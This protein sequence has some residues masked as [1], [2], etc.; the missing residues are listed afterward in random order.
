MLELESEAG[1]GLVVILGLP[2]VPD[3]CRDVSILEIPLLLWPLAR[4]GPEG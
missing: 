1:G 2:P 4:E 3:I